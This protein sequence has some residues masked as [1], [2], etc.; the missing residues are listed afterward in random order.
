MLDR[1]ALYVD[2][3]VSQCL[4]SSSG[5]GPGFAD[6]VLAAIVAALAMLSLWMLAQGFRGRDDA[7]S[8]RIKTAVLED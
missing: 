7:R 4:P 8:R 5:A 3:V 2:L 6:D 1:L